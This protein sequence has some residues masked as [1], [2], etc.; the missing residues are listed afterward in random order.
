MMSQHTQLSQT[1]GASLEDCHTNFFTLT[2]LVGINWRVYTWESSA[3]SGSHPAFNNVSDTIEDP[4]LSSYAR[5]L[6]ADVLCVWRR[7]WRR[8]P[9]VIDPLLDGGPAMPSTSCNNTNNSPDTPSKNQTNLK[10]SSKQLWIFWYGEEPD[11]SKLV[12]PELTKSDG[13]KGSWDWDTGLSYECRTILFKALHNLIERCL[14]REDFVRLG[15]WFVQPYEAVDCSSTCKSTH[16]SFSLSFFVHGESHVCASVDVRQQPPVRRL[17]A[18]HLAMAAAAAAASAHRPPAPPSAAGPSPAAAPNNPPAGLPVV[19]APYS[20]SGILT[21]VSYRVTDPG[22]Q[23]ILDDWKQFFPLSSRRR[24][25]HRTRTSS[26]SS[27]DG[28]DNV[29]DNTSEG[30]SSSASRDEWSYVSSDEDDLPPVVEVLVGGFRLKYPSFYVLVTDLDDVNLPKT[31]DGTEGSPNQLPGDPTYDN[32]GCPP[33][34]LKP[35]VSPRHTHSPFTASTHPLMVANF[36]QPETRASVSRGLGERVWQDVVQCHQTSSS[37]GASSSH[38]GLSSE[39]CSLTPAEL[40]GRWDFADPATKLPCTCSKCVGSSGSSTS[41]SSSSSTLYKGG[42]GVTTPG[43]V[44]SLRTGGGGGGGG[45]GVLTDGPPASVESQASITPSPL[46]TPHSH[47]PSVT[48]HHDASMPTL[49][50]QPP[51]SNA[52]LGGGDPATPLDPS[53]LDTKPCLADLL[54]A[55]APASVKMASAAQVSSPYRGP[56]QDSNNTHES[57]FTSGQQLAMRGLKRHIMPSS[58]YQDACNSESHTSSLYDCSKL[59]AWYCHPVKRFR[60]AENKVEEPLWPPY[61][62]PHHAAPPS[63]IKQEHGVFENTDSNATG[64]ATGHCSPSPCL[65]HNG[66]AQSCKRPTSESSSPSRLPTLKR[67]LTGHDPYVFDDEPAATNGLPD[68]FKREIDIK[69]EPKDD[70][71]PNSP[72]IK[73]SDLYTSEGLH[74]SPSDLEKIFA[75]DSPLDDNHYR[76]HTPPGS[77]HSIGNIDDMPQSN[78]CSG[79]GNIVANLGKSNCSVSASTA[80]G[81]VSLGELTKMYPTPPSLEHNN[82]DHDAACD[83]QEPTDDFSLTHTPELLPHVLKED[84]KGSNI[85]RPLPLS[86]FVGSERYKPLTDLPSMRDPVQILPG[87]VY[88][89]S[90]PQNSNNNNNTNVNNNSS[91]SN[92]LVEKLQRPPSQLPPQLGTP[93]KLGAMSPAMDRGPGSV[94]GPSSVGPSLGYELAS[95]ASNQSYLSKAVAS[96]EPSTLSQTPEASALIV[97]MVLMDSSLNLFRD[98][99]FDSCPMCVCNNDHKVVGNVRGSDGALYLPSSYLSPSEEAI[100]CNCGFS[101]VVNRRLAFQSGLFYEDEVD[102]TGLH[103]GLLTERRK[104]SLSNLVEKSNKNNDNVERD[105]SLLD[106]MPESLFQ[107]VQHQCVD[108][109]GSSSSVVQRAAAVYRSTRPVLK[110]NLVDIKD[111]NDL[112][113]LALEQARLDE[114][115]L[116]LRLSCMHKW[117]YYQYDGPACSQDLA[118]CMTALQPHLQEAIQK[119]SRPWEPVFNVRGPLTWRHFLRMAF[120][121]TEDMAEPL[122][123]PMLLAGHDRDWVSVAPQAIKHWERLMLEPY[124]QQRAIAYVVVSP[125]NEFVLNH[126][127]TFFKELSSV[128]QM[129]RLGRHA[130]IQRVLVDGIMRVSKTA[131]AKVANESLDDWFTLLDDSQISTKLKFYSQVCRHFLAPHLSGLRMDKTLFEVGK[132]RSGNSTNSGDQMQRQAS[133]SPMPPPSLGPDGSTG[134]VDMPGQTQTDGYAV[135]AGSSFGSGCSLVDSEE[136]E[137]PPPA[138]MIYL[139]DPFSVGHD[140]PEMHRLITLGLLRCYK[141]MLDFLPQHM[142][143]NVHVQIIS[144]ESIVELA[145]DTHNISRQSDQLK[146]LAFSVFTQCRRFLT[147][148]N[149]V[150]SLTGFG[151]AS[152]YDNFLKPRDP[153]EEEEVRAPYPVCSPPYILA[154]VKENNHKEAEEALGAPREK[155]TV[156]HCTYCLSED[157]HWLLAAATDNHGE[158]LDTITINI[159]VPNRTRRKKA[160]S[161]RP[162]LKKLMEWI[163]GVMSTGVHPWRLVVGKLGRMGHGELKGWL[164]LLSR[165]SL[166]ASSKNLRDLCKQCDY[167]FPGAAPCILSACL[168]SLEP[169]STFR[170]MPD[171]FT[172]DERFGHTSQNCNLNT[173][174]DVTCTHILVFPTSA[175]AQ[176]AQRFQDEYPF[177]FVNEDSLLLDDHMDG[178]GGLNYIDI[179]NMESSGNEPD[180]LD[181]VAIGVPESLSQSSSPNNAGFGGG[182]SRGRCVSPSQQ[183]GQALS[184]G[185]VLADPDE[186]EMATLLQQPLALG[187]YVSTAGTGKLPQW[188]WSACPHLENVC[189]VFL[190]SALHLNQPAVTQA[191]AEDVLPNTSNKAHP[192]DSACTADVLRYV[193]EGYNGLSWLALDPTTQDRRSCLP[194]HMQALSNLYNSVAALV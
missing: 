72:A 130:P 21:G 178:M 135:S 46:P 7:S 51:P 1:N 118:R 163:L 38:E 97:N 58:D 126:V 173:P 101:A 104:S 154:S 153:N 6:S 113:Q 125:D 67:P 66:L 122:P 9:P 62:P 37:S 84:I 49:S 106:H 116:T 18:A 107:L 40:A 194:L 5:C 149:S 93:N 56:G 33:V 39:G 17:R 150:R 71:S 55:T 29:G 158:M 99:N 169:D 143:A 30:L 11:L 133:M 68:G 25:R 103:D 157:Q 189:P 188:F 57:H 124:C 91:T 96:V 69:E 186:D 181:D 89:P 117:A 47:P 179:V 44:P 73:K 80:A 15:K 172:P 8:P 90:W 26:G 43:S 77:N 3:G 24:H 155:S 81:S 131:A 183:N 137:G 64:I 20:L 139:V 53:S 165:K 142:Q 162:G 27:S 13:T 76:D 147:H 127:R 83:D 50:P 187:Y 152:V 65:Q 16:L 164:H 41:S 10:H 88:R 115:P 185:Q 128:Y 14:L 112:A 36:V 78:S 60:T 109:L 2:D 86:M 87:S 177:Q 184:N 161:R 176:S 100:E 159:E 31:T 146:C 174:Q 180:P 141:Q 52:S 94:G 136:D 105:T 182:D 111:G 170:M 108:T 168:V 160:S 12:A 92:N 59:D 114:S 191:E 132:S 45:G 134:G 148:T 19:L 151:P 166:M 42:C 98:H 95:P 82:F 145:A 192:L 144:L 140:H 32:I 4:V 75:N 119:K 28:D 34:P 171:V 48:P 35:R 23:K 110:I 63:P 121:G 156:L 22:I 120:R 102:L 193:L 123:V 74:P 167:L 175:T 138:I 190:K 129:C 70:M 54:A 79:V 61:R 85:F